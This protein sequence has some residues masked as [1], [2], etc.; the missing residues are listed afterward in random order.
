MMKIRSAEPHQ[1]GTAL[2]GSPEAE[3][4][5]T[6]MARPGDESPQARGVDEPEFWGQLPGGERAL[7]PA[8]H[9]FRWTGRDWEI[10]F[11]GGRV[12][13]LPNVLGSR[14]LNYLLHAPNE[15]IEAFALEVAIQP[16]KGEARSRNSI[17][18]ES[19]PQALSEYRQELGRLQV[20]RQARRR[21]V[22]RRKSSAWWARL[23]RWSRRSAGVARPIRAS[24]R[25][26]TF[27]WRS[28][29]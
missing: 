28:A 10:Y 18:A 23:R 15:P 24:G 1:W 2:A 26:A 27:A 9:V 21:R 20:E 5:T 25:A 16:E 22:G 6:A 13:H 19:D 3:N 29:P 8:T 11:R 17:Q 7:S 4:P 12:F 14:Y